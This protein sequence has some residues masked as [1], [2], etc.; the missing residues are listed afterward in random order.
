MAKRLLKNNPTSIKVDKLI[1]FMNELGLSLEY[2]HHC[3]VFYDKDKPD[4]MVEYRDSDNSSGCIE[5]PS[6]FEHKLII[7]NY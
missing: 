2:S 3:L 1:D 4:K 7:D 6:P 5:L